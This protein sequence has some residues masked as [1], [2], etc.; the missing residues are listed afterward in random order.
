MK[1]YKSCYI[2]EPMSREDIRYYAQQIRK[3]FGLEQWEAIDPSKL[4]DKLSTLL[5][6]QEFR[7]DYEVLPDNDKRFGFREEAKT[8]IQN[9]IIYFKESVMNDGCKDHT[10]A[11]FTIM[12]E[13]G[14][15][16]LHYLHGQIS[17]SRIRENSYLIPC[18]DPEW[19]ANAFASEILMPFEICK[20]LTVE[21]IMKKYNVSK[22]AAT[23]RK[24][25]V[26]EE[27]IRNNKNKNL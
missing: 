22:T 12:H 9:G 21:Q 7:F 15:Y 18:I 20:E 25:M 26:R 8:D 23:V 13:L 3:M 24:R 4:L 17:L 5:A 27:I 6:K 16:L 14:H 19:Q 10:R 11:R 2:A 1:N